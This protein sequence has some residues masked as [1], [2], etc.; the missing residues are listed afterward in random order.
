MSDFWKSESGQGAIGG[1]INA[2]LGLG[3]SAFTAN[4]V[5]QNLKGQANL[6]AQQAKD[7]IALEQERTKQAELALKAVQSQG[8][9]AG[10]NTVLYVALG[11]SGV[12][13]LGVV[14]Y[15]VTKK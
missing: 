2:L 10:S 1:G 7:A 4:Q 3:T 11:I 13:V 14:I 5:K 12:L 9:K 15:A 6:S 8:A